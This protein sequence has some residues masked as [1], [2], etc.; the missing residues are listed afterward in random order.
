MS[1]KVSV[2][3]KLEEIIETDA[4]ATNKRAFFQKTAEGWRQKAA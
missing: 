2:R 4:A 1:G 3:K